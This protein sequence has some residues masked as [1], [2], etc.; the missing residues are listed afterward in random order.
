[1]EGNKDIHDRSSVLVLSSS[2][3][4]VR[5]KETVLQ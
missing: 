3:N 4:R 5:R 2:E 1:M